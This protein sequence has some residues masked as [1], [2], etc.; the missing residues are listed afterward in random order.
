MGCL[1]NRELE[2]QKSTAGKSIVV[3]FLALMVSFTLFVAGSDA[4][5][6]EASEPLRYLPVQD[7][8]RIKP[9]DTFARESLMLVY[10][11]ETYKSSKGDRPAVDIILTWLLVP[12]HWDEQKIIRIDHRGLKES[13]KLDLE[14]KYFVPKVIFNNQRLALVFQE[15][16]SFSATKQKMTPYF[17]AVQRLQDQLGV[18]QAIKMGQMIRV[19]PP[20]PEAAAESE[21]KPGMAP[22]EPKRWLSVAELD[23]E[24]KEKFAE[25]IHALARSL[26]TESGAAEPSSTADSG[27]TGSSLLEAVENFKSLARSRNPALYPSDRDIAIEV[28]ERTLHPFKITWILYLLTAVLLA[29]AW[30]S[31]QARVYHAGCVV[32]G[33]AFLMHTYGFALRVYLTG[34][35]PVSNMYESVVWVSWGCLV[36]SMVFEYLYRSRFILLAG[37]AVAV[38]C[39]VVADLAPT[40]L[41]ASLQPL[42]PV[43]RSNMWLTIHVLTI[44]LSYSAFFLAWCLGNI[45]LGLLLKGLRPGDERIKG[46]VNAIYRALQVGVVL[47]AAGIILG[48]IWADYSW[49]RFWGWDPKE[50]W[51]FIALMGYLAALH[52]RLVGWVRNV[53]MMVISVVAFNLIIMAWYG[54]N[55]VLGAGLHT[56]GMGAGGVQYV[57]GFVVINLLFVFYSLFVERSRGLEKNL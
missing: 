31:G 44:T 53:G 45:G 6:K 7:A 13:L 40:I 42:E 37:S 18:Y 17:S 35:P 4:L 38:I 26:P 1:S 51:A 12:E 5:A 27:V 22:A 50:T 25:I 11:S 9:F 43:L 46:L 10:G 52:G 29:V 15:L 33:L 8:G 57:A 39:L 56:Y 49:G 41:D 3:L 20:T 30:Q 24:L 23:G 21:P 32:A 36:F 55:Y 47:L 2:N 34:R 54:V 16:Q 19:V 28:H 48:G 14:E